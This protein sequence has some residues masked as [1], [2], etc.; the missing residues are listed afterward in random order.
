MSYRVLAYYWK[1]PDELEECGWCYG[2]IVGGS[3][4]A[5]GWLPERVWKAEAVRP[6]CG[7]SWTRTVGTIELL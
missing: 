5:A 2:E 1:G 7:V 3:G 4:A 6:P